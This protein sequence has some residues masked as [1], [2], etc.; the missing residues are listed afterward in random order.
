MPARAGRILLNR[1]LVAAVAAVCAVAGIASPNQAAGAEIQPHEA[2]YELVLEDHAFGEGIESS[3]G[4][5]EIRYELGC[6]SWT[7][8]FT[9]DFTI[10]LSAG[11]P[12]NFSYMSRTEEALDGATFRFEHLELSDGE[13]VQAIAGTAHNTGA[14]PAEAVFTY[15]QAKRLSLPTQTMF[16]IAAWRDLLAKVGQ[17]PN[18]EGYT[19]FDGWDV[20]GPGVLRVWASMSKLDPASQSGSGPD[21]ALLNGNSWQVSSAYF[22]HGSSDMEPASSTDERLYDTGVSDLIRFDW[23]ELVIRAE[24]TGVKPLE[25]P[26]C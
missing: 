1:K 21:N 17:E 16:P 25:R 5:M 13:I 8:L 20:E 2:H 14:G 19:L 6:A 18:A 4:S 12:V 3:G 26:E 15:P 7:T 9:F 24:S 11:P 23:Q 22:P 10:A